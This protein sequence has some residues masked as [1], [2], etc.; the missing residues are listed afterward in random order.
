MGC[1]RSTGASRRRRTPG[2]ALTER[3]REYR[4]GWRLAAAGPE[5]VDLDLGL[6]ATRTEPVAGGREAEH[7]VGLT[8]TAS[9]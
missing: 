7:A 5:A 3:A 6:Q 8:M 4:L 2:S 1:R 9:W